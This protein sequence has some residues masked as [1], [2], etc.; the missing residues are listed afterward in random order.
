M[1]RL[2]SILMVVFCISVPF[3]VRASKASEGAS[4]QRGSY[5]AERGVIVPSE[6]IYIDSYI[7]SID[8]SYPVPE[9]IDFG[10]FMY[11]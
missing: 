2:I 4:E 10:V 5:L 8:Y 11:S 1:K 6:D 3:T 7:G 9:S